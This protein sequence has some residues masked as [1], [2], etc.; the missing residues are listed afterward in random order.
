[1]P[2]AEPGL[3]KQPDARTPSSK[4]SRNT[5]AAL[6]SSFWQSQLQELLRLQPKGD[7]VYQRLLDFQA[8]GNRMEPTCVCN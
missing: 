1:M 8:G 2:N 7:D 6:T 5:L 4:R 3:P